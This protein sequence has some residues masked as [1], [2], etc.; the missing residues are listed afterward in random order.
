MLNKE[1]EDVTETYKKYEC[2]YKIFKKIPFI[3]TLLK[4]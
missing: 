4:V 3:K 2:F 1:N